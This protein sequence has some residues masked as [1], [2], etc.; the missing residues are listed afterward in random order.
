MLCTHFIAYCVQL[1][2]PRQARRPRFHGFIGGES[3]GIERVTFGAGRDLN[4]LD[5]VAGFSQQL[6]KQ[7]AF[8][9]TSGPAWKLNA[10]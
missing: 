6:V 3:L 2:A 4:S 7:P 5:P 1:I 8:P 9:I 10:F